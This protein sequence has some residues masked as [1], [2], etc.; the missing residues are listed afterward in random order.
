MGHYVGCVYVVERHRPFR[1]SD[2][3]LADHF[4]IYFQRGFL[5]YLQNFSQTESPSIAAVRNLFNGV[6]LSPEESAQLSLQADE[7]WVCF[8]LKELR[9]KKYM[10][11]DYMYATINSLMPRTAY[12]VIHN[13]AVVGLLRIRSEESNCNQSTLEVFREILGRMDY[14]CGLSCEFSDPRKFRDYYLQ[15]SYAA[16]ICAQSNS[17]QVLTYFHDHILQYMLYTCASELSLESLYSKGMLALLDYDK[18]RNTDYVK[19]LDTYLKNEMSITRTSE[20]LYIHRSSL[21]KRLDKINQLIDADLNDPNVRLYFRI[22]FRLQ[23]NMH[24]NVVAE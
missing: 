19:T 14:I 10:P 5:K 4:F 17:S 23:E 8:K 3:P 21:L 15:A 9:Y 24:D 13:D 2:F 11:K 20:A 1:E 7:K 22:C 12:S 16:E 18:R 6:P